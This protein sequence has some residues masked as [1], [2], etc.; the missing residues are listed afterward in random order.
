MKR[1]LIAAYAILVALVCPEVMRAAVSVSLSPTT[2][3]V[4]PGGQTQ[5]AATVSGTT[6]DVVIWSLA[7]TNCSG[8]ACGQIT[9]GGVYLAPRTAPNPNV[10]TV[11]AT[12]LADL[13]ASASAAVIVGTSSDITVTV[14]P[15]TAKVLVGQQQRFVAYVTG[16]TLTGVTWQLS[17][18]AC[19]SSGCGTI[20][21]T[22]VYTAPP[23]LPSSPVTVQA[24]SIAD[25]T[26]SGSAAVTVALPVAVNVSPTSATLNAGKQQQFTANV[27]NTTNTAVTWSVTGPGCTGSGCGTITAS[28]L[29]TAP[30]SV[31][32]PATVS[33]TATSVADT[34][35]SA[36]AS[37]T[38]IPP[39]AVS[40]APTTAQLL[41]GTHQQFT[42][43]VTNTANTS[44]TWSVSGAGC[45]G[46]ACGTITAGGYYT[47]P[48]TVPSPALVSVIAT[49][50]ADPTRSSKASVTIL[51]PV[52]VTI[53]PTTVDVVT[54]AHQQ[55]TATVTNT[56]NTAVTWSVSGTGCSGAVCGTISTSGL[57]T[58]PAS[59]PSSATVSVT[60]TSVADT[61]KSA[62]ASVTIVPP[63]GISITPASV[64]LLVGKQQ[65]FTASVTH[66]TN[67]AVTWSIAG[68]GCSGAACGTITTGGLFTAPSTLPSPAE[69][70]VTA[71]SV[72]DPTKSATASVSLTAP[73]AVSISPTMA[74]LLAGAHQQFNATVANSSNTAVTWSIGGTGCS[75][76]ACGT[77]TTSGLYTAPAKAPS[78][79]AITV[80]AT[81]VADTTK[82]AQAQVTIVGPVAVN[83]SPTSATVSVGLTQ[84]F[85]ATVTGSSNTSVSW[86]VAG[87]GCTGAACGTVT[88]TGLYTAPFVLP[89]P[90]QVFVTATSNADSTRSSTAAI[91]LVPL[92]G[93]SVSPTTATLTTGSHQQFTATVVGTTNT[94][95]TWSVSGTG[96]S[97]S[98]CGV[99]SSTGLYT[100]PSTVPSPAQVTVKAAS[101]A[102]AS[103]YA[104]ATVTIIPPVAVTISPTSADVVAGEHQQFSATVTGNANTNVTWSVSGSGCKGAAC[105]VISSTGLYNAPGAV[106]SPAHVTV[107]A[108]SVVDTSKSA[109]AT[110]TIIP[111]VAVTI[112]PAVVQ[113]VTG[114]HQQFTATV[115]GTQNSS[116]TWT[117]SGKGCSG[118]A[119]GTITPAGL[120]TAPG[121]I[122]SPAQ[123]TITATAEADTTKSS[124]ATITIIPPVHVAISPASLVLAI[125]GQQQFRA[126]VTGSSNTSI[127]WSVSG[128]GCSGSACGIINSAGLYTAPGAVP[129]PATVIVKASS[130]IDPTQSAS[131][132]VTLAASENA[133]LQGPFAFQFTGF[134]SSGIYQSAGSFMADGNGNIKAGLEDVNSTAGPVTDDS[135]TGTYQLG[136]DNRGTMTFSTSRGSQT[137]RFTLNLTA[138]GGRFI[139]FDSTGIRGSGVLEKQDPAA[140]SLSA[141]DGAYVLSLAGKD[142]AG[143]RIGALGI[144][145]LNGI[146]SIPGG[147]MD[148]NDGGMVAPT[149]GSFSGIYR[150]DPTGRGILNLSIPGFAG[151]SFRFAFYIVSAEKMFLISIDPLSSDNP[152]FSGPVELQSGAPYLTSSFSGPTTFS[153]SGEQG[154]VSQVLVG[155]IVFD[156][157]SQP[158]VEFDENTGGTVTTNN[159]L[160]GAYAVEVNGPGALNLDDS[161]GH[162]RTWDMYA[163]GPNHA[164]LMDTSS[165]YVGMGELTPQSV[166][167]PFSNADILGTYLLGSG[168]PLVPAASL[169]S[170]ITNYDGTNTMSG[171]E[172]ISRSSA[173]LPAQPMAGAYSLSTSLNN[174]RGTLTLM[175]PSGATIAL[176]AT[177]PSQVIG[178]DIDSSNATPV[179]LYFEQ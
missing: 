29:Y 78:P 31:P 161:D 39:V 123:V 75:G 156:G 119:C 18:P 55:F 158:R 83:I 93:V 154:N 16:T 115:T 1:I 10:V 68:S 42:A 34:T 2:V 146:G 37:V 76:S 150:V 71:T 121:T 99:I 163:I 137:F 131:A 66:A 149:Y 12:S 40:V 124:S 41:T 70:F 134:D 139:E 30:S 147:S 113:V 172:D 155:R 107:T 162:S 50:V 151:G 56:A 104:T 173:L 73:V 97:G 126:T 117:L 84:Q 46:S 53:A 45:S 118:S 116:V 26:R 65:Q 47:A 132:T 112:S 138:T 88:A 108:T 95:V 57:Y 49:S 27:T 120:Y 110:V 54:G 153:L 3:S 64:Q 28:G 148:I 67:T 114:Q 38:I 22:G 79:D 58:A 176:W 15:A 159:V 94:G 178:L 7:G 145:D 169:F 165:A 170:G 152:I 140:F 89:S 111:P 21:S 135:F 23:T 102:N 174:G 74:Q 51:A 160:T 11:T 98:T 17:G 24:V 141:F 130:L 87:S 91:S 133:R 103:R 63:L 167:A 52:A 122:P 127:D 86:S 175:K 44:V 125:N 177:S 101:V 168:E 13:S 43:T 6:N 48:S 59:I 81:S 72:A 14:S 32:S 143:N 4:Q 171:T 96:C 19:A 100:A 164:F 35:K 61:T 109:S 144:V 69:V 80:T 129:S 128:A 157:I 5:F 62:S 166:T 82:S 90:A 8:V 25:P 105:G 77:I 142:S 106:P 36:A 33:V 92:I 179:V 20:S 60:A 9:S 85:S 136:A